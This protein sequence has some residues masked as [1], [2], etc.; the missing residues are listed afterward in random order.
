LSAVIGNERAPEHTLSE[1][2]F[3]FICKL[4]YDSTGIVLDERKR[5]MVYRRMMRRTRDLK[6]GSFKE[7]LRL[8]KDDEKV[9][10]PSFINA[11]TT[12]LTSFF[13]EEHH[14]DYLREQFIP[15]HLSE[16]KHTNKLR[17]WSAA[18]ST[19]EEPYSLAITLIKALPS[20][21]SSWDIKILATDLDT[22]VLATAKNGI[23]KAERIKD[24]SEADKK[25]WFV[26]G[27]GANV[28]KVKVASE[29]QSLITF[30]QLNLL[31]DWP[32]HGPFDVIL[33]RNVLIYFDR[34]TQAKLIQRYHQLLRPGGVLMLGHSESLPKDSSGFTA[35]GRTIFTKDRMSL[36][37]P[38]VMR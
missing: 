25:K 13:R 36:A 3:G 33:C 4:V 27:S 15:Q 19:G 34:P 29:L 32:M 28:D 22:D 17:I 24:L 16:Y 18:C 10:F 20:L 1:K 38:R 7:Y 35:A 2:D 11:I 37:Q 8:L 21:I 31:N 12:N 5:E 9:E 30:K 26:S 6:L 14:F 23:Y